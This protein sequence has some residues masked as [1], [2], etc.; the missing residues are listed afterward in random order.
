M[1]PSQD[2]L[3]YKEVVSK[4]FVRHPP[5]TFRKDV[6]TF[7]SYLGNPEKSF[8]VVHI[9]GTNGKGSVAVTIKFYLLKYRHNIINCFI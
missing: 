6:A 8:K 2:P 4:L 7:A 5:V 1:E 3:D 9:T